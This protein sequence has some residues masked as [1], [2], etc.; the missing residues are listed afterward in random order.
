MISC[1]KK[2]SRFSALRGR[3]KCILD[4]VNCNRVELQVAGGWG[5]VVC[6]SRVLRCVV[7]VVFFRNTF[8]L[9]GCF[10]GEV[11]KF[12]IVDGWISGLLIWIHLIAGQ[13]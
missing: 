11:D 7:L 1:F 10:G 6:S 12:G 8:S 13:Q 3:I 9:E 2:I 5:E 4:N